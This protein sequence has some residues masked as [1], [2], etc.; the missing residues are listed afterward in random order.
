MSK[1]FR[2]ELRRL[3]RNKLFF[4]I[5]VISLLYGWLTLTGV[6]IRGVAHTAPFSPW[7][8]GQYLARI[9]PVICLGELFFLTFFTSRKERQV[10]IITS[11]APISPG[12]YAA[13]R[14]GAVLFGTTLLV[15]FCVA[16]AFVYYI[17]YF[18]WSRFGEL[19]FPAAL[20][21][22]PAILFSL[23]LGQSLGRL[24]PALVYGAMP[25][26]FL[27]SFLPLPQAVDFSME[28]FF[29]DYP[30]TLEGPDPAFAVAIPVLLGRLGY[31]A[32]GIVLFLQ[33]RKKT[34]LGQS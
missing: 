11:A 16:L 29:T 7:S 8:F 3:L 32:A 23:G 25:L 20:V 12:K 30:L 18:G 21:L 9:L 22:L 19:I 5:L 17:R 6:T 10:E 31:L 27:F 28:S 34:Y 4:G 1:I 15:L 33:G 24:H 13:V 14:C 2:Y 26:P